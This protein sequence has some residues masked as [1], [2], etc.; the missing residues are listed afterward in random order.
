M[1]IWSTQ[2]N[3]KLEVVNVWVKKKKNTFSVFL[4]VFKNNWLLKAKTNVNECGGFITYV[5]GEIMTMIVPK[6]G[7]KK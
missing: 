6:S 1:K 4:N 2:K 3:E 5:E 7:K